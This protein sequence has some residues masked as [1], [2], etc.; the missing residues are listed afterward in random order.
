MT[1]VDRTPWV[2]FRFLYRKRGR[3]FAKLT[4][5]PVLNNFYVVDVLKANK[6][7]P[8][9]RFP[10]PIPEN[11]PA[12]STW[13]GGLKDTGKGVKREID[14]NCNDGV[15]EVSDDGLEALE[16]TCTTSR[17]PQTSDYMYLNSG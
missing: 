17:T 7:L 9:S 5:V 10:S 11:S 8:Q 16:V 4:I 3:I 1:D 6:I 13:V 2:I 15:V 12:P 14:E